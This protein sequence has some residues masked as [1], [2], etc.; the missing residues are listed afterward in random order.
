M[1]RRPYPRSRWLPL[2]L[3]DRQR[4][5]SELADQG[6]SLGEIARR[7]GLAVPTVKQHRDYALA[8]A[9]RRAELRADRETLREVL[10]GSQDGQREPARSS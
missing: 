5:V 2:E 8:K 6:L 1:A 10:H 9:I 7:L 4:E 3:T